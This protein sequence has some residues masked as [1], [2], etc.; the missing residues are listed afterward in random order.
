MATVKNYS[1]AGVSS[2]L[3]FGKAGGKIDFT[4]GKFSVKDATGTDVALTTATPAAADNTTKVATTAYVQTE[5][6][7]FNDDRIQDST[8]NTSLIASA[9]T[10]SATVGTVAQYTLTNGKFDLLSTTLLSAANGTSAAPGIAFDG[11]VGETAGL[12]FNPT[13]SL[14]TGSQTVMSVDALPLETWEVAAAATAPVTLNNIMSDTEAKMAATGTATNIDIRLTPKGT[15]QVFIGDGGSAASIGSGDATLA[16]VNAE[17]M[18]I[19]GGN[20]FTGSATSNGGSI[21]LTP[22]TGG[23]GSL[24]GIVNVQDNAGNSVMQFIG[25]ASAVNYF[26]ATNSATGGSVDIAASGTDTNINIS[27]TPKGPTGF[28]DA[29]SSLISNVTDP[30]GAQDAA[31]KGYVD[32]ATQ[33]LDTSRIHDGTF[34]AQGTTFIDTNATAGQIDI[35]SVGPVVFTTNGTINAGT[36]TITNVVDP[37]ALQDAAT[38]NYVDNA[39]S[40]ITTAGAEDLI[41]ATNGLMIVDGVEVASAVNHIRISNAITGTVGPVIESFGETNVDLQLKAAGTGIVRISDSAAITGTLT[42]GGTLNMSSQLI[43]SVLDPVSAQDAATKAYVDGVAA[44]LD[45]KA[46]VRVATTVAGTLATSFAAA[47]TIDGI[48]LVAGD[49]ILIKNQAAGSENGIYDVQASGAPVRSADADNLPGSEVT[50]GM[51]TFAEE[52]TLNANTGWV[53][54]T[55][56]VITLN[57]TALA[58]SQ[59][60]GAGAYTNTG[61]A[62]ITATQ[63]GTDFAIVADVD[64]AT[65]R[66]IGGTGAQ[67]AVA[68]GANNQILVGNTGA[69]A[70]WTYQNSLRG[71]TDGSIGVTSIDT[72]SAVNFLTVTPT[73]TA[74]ADVTLAATGADPDIS[75]SLTPKGAGFIDVANDTAGTSL[76]S[77]VADPVSPQDAATLASVTAAIGAISTTTIT[78]GDS[79][80]VVADAGVGAITTTVDGTV[81]STASVSLFDV[82]VQISGADGTAA[83]PAYAFNT[84]VTSGMYY[85]ATGAASFAEGGVA[86]LELGLSGVHATITALGTNANIMLTPSGTGFIDATNS[87]I[88]NVT[89]PVAGTDAANKAYVDSTVA[90]AGAGDVRTLKTTF[91]LTAAATLPFSAAIPAG[92]TVT[93]ITMKVTTASDTASTVVVGISGNTGKYMAAL[94]NDPAATGLYISEVMELEASAVT[95]DVVVATPGTVGSVDIIIEYRAA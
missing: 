53:L 54:T 10:L 47:S 3:Q 55:S 75:L 60:S 94:E 84:D 13:G 25:V 61:G 34:P 39:T 23:T 5:L 50:T 70:S 15:G 65:I 11:V 4:G 68:G 66:N 33:G 1:L 56:G 7:A 81:V 9:T 38:K 16:T 12:S 36:A 62:G 63:T 52:G 14:A 35:T 80:I 8:G 91:A 42:V 29:T 85:S 22:G 20:G 28:I 18:S 89:T 71:T 31:T 87:L 64:G 32:S 17:T 2:N 37:S 58:F 21:L 59:F 19:T 67:L 44:G 72:P 73:I 43:S 45:V 69:D 93:R 24:N 41:G 57:T 74:G 95:P 92:A 86:A 83:A 51:F 30:V 79:S 78:Q 88:S 49:R 48:T 27:L 26:T 76:I 6:S 46:S 40:L 90:T 82:N 77:N